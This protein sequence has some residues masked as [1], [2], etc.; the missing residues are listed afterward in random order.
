[1]KIASVK[2]AMPSS[3]NGRPITSPYVDISPGHSRPISKLRI[4]PETAPTANST[5]AT[6]AHLL[7]EVERDRRRRAQ[8]P[9]R[10]TT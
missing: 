4:V 1:M 6:F 2:N 3:A 10:W 8:T 5:A 7:G 9:R